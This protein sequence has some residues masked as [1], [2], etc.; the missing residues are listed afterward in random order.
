V[1]LPAGYAT[2]PDYGKRSVRGFIEHKFPDAH[3][4]ITQVRIDLAPFR[5][6]QFVVS[7]V[8]IHVS[9]NSC[10]TSIALCHASPSTGAIWT[11]SWTPQTLTLSSRVAS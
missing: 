9:D 8:L 5:P 3:F 2:I 1:L 7:V 10:R 11:R 6:S 4:A